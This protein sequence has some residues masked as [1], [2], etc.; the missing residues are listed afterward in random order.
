MNKLLPFVFMS[1]SAV[2]LL[3]AM[4][5]LWT[6]LR[7]LFGGSTEHEI[8]QS[9]ALRRR[10]EMLDEKDGVLASLKDLEFERS[11]G[12]ISEADFA[13]LDADFRARARSLIKQLDEDLKEHREKARAL[14]QRQLVKADV[15]TEKLPQISRSKAATSGDKSA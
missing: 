11:V 14:M 7:G 12:K 9:P 8:V 3:A 13:R 2:A 1:L 6:S 15:D 10:M 5:F 4:S